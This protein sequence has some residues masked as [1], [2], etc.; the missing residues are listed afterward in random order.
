LWN[1][2]KAVDKRLRKPLWLEPYGQKQCAYPVKNSKKKFV[3][4]IAQ[5]LTKP[6]ERMQ[7]RGFVRTDPEF[8]TP[9]V[10]ECKECVF[11]CHYGWL[12]AGTLPVVRVIFLRLLNSLRD[13]PMGH[14]EQKVMV[15][16][17]C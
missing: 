1:P 9:L 7:H 4:R 16:H 10:D 5:K 6:G 8:S 17:P 13:F 3:F 12:C 11:G 14:H 2:E 15:L